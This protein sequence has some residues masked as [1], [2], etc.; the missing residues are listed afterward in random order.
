MLLQYTGFQWKSRYTVVTFRLTTFTDDH[1]SKK[2]RIGLCED[3]K[4]TKR[5]YKSKSKAIS[6]WKCR[7]VVCRPYTQDLQAKSEDVFEEQLDLFNT[8]FTD[9]FS[10]SVAYLK[11]KIWVERKTLWRPDASYYT[12]NM[13]EPYHNKMRLCKHIFLVS[14]AH[15]IAYNDKY[16]FTR[17][18]IASNDTG[19]TDIL[20]EED[21]I[22]FQGIEEQ[23]KQRFLRVDLLS[24]SLK[25]DRDS[26]VSIFI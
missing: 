5:K 25:P 21:V 3:G 8:Y 13:I 12:N 24:E 1:Y 17:H 14:R 18:L 16:A 15:A 7:R 2:N 23:E 20:I 22:G 19:A 10:S 4:H 26:K 9:R 6:P 11:K